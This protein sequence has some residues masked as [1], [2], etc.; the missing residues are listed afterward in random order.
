MI[1]TMWQEVPEFLYQ[2]EWQASQAVPVGLANSLGST[3]TLHSRGSRPAGVAYG[4]SGGSELQVGKDANGGITIL[5]DAGQNAQAA[6][7]R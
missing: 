3:V 7:T 6:V 1:F 4:G 2:T 5:A